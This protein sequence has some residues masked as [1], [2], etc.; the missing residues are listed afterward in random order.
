MIP[1]AHAQGPPP[2]GLGH[3]QSNAGTRVPKL[4]VR[5]L[6][7]D[8]PTRAS[9]VAPTG[10]RGPGGRDRDEGSAEHATS[11]EKDRRA[12]FLE[13]ADERLGGSGEPKMSRHLVKPA[14]RGS[15]LS[16]SDRQCAPSL[17]T[18]TAVCA[19]NKGIPP[20][21]LSLQCLVTLAGEERCNLRIISIHEGERVCIFL[22]PSIHRVG[23]RFRPLAPCVY[24][25]GERS[26]SLP[27]A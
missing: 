21:K 19:R 10:H 6:P 2:S 4:A 16:G 5:P 14:D 15:S 17:V 18:T 22:P 11:G 12:D 8:L 24:R 3:N 13:R 1:L 26:I 7:G 20:P 25:V 23:V 9:D 27:P